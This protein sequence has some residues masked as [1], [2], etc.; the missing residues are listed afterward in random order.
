MLTKNESLR[1]VM[2]E[3]ISDD[4][5]DAGVVRAACEVVAEEAACNE[6]MAER[7][8]RSDPGLFFAAMKATFEQVEEARRSWAAFVKATEPSSAPTPEAR[9]SLVRSL[10]T[11]RDEIRVRARWE[12]RP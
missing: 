6:R 2:I 4:R 12:P 9:T 5:S 3:V 8:G 11:I 10:N 1:D 7:Q